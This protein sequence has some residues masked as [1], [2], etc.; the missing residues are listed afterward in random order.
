MD[1]RHEHTV[2]LEAIR[3]AGLQ[4][5]KLNAEGFE[6]R[7]K[8]D[9]SPVTSADL[10]VNELLRDRLL[11]AFPHDGWLSEESPDNEGRL[12]KSRVWL[13][14]PIDGTKAFIRKEPD[15]CIAVALVEAG[16]PVVAAVYNPSTDELF[17]ALRGSGLLLND[18]PITGSAVP[19]DS[20]RPVMALSPWE[21]RMGRFQALAGHITSRPLRSIAWAM[22]L[23]AAGRIQAVATCEPEHEWDVAAGALLVTEA[24]GSAHDGAGGVLRFNRPTP[25]YRGLVAL[26]RTCPPALARH[27]RGLCPNQ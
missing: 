17:S 12:S 24:G 10:A 23:A 22:A 14:D 5:L 16:Q 8:A 19:A 26:S 3:V 13:V 18:R 9:R 15:Y 7:T 2:L 20:D 6:V 1:W 11:A 25:R 27:L 21:Q 4:A